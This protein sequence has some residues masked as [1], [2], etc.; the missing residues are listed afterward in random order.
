MRENNRKPIEKCRRKLPQ[1]TTMNV[2]DG[3]AGLVIY[4]SLIFYSLT[5]DNILNIIVLLILAG[6]TIA[7]LTGDNGILTNATKAKEENAKAEVIDQAR[8]DILAKQTEKQGESPTAEE[9]E[10][11]L[12]PKYGTLSNE[13]K[14][15]DRTL[16]T[17]EGYQIL[18]RDIWNGS[19]IEETK[20]PIS[21]TESYVGN[22]ADID[23][24][25]EI[26]GIIYADLAIGNTVEGGWLGKITYTITTED[27]ANLKD[28]YIKETDH[29][30][31]SGFGTGNVITPMDDSNGKDRFYVMALTDIGEGQYYSWYSNYENLGNLETESGFGTGKTNTE[32]MI[33]L[34]NNDSNRDEVNDL[35]GYIKEGWFVP[36]L[37][38]WIAFAGELKIDQNNYT[39]K[40]LSSDYWTS[41]HITYIPNFASCINF[42]YGATAGSIYNG[43]NFVRLSTTF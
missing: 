31:E 36:S 39:D 1:F 40:G 17:K 5:I 34:W 37:D 8:V 13:E 2:I 33:N 21:K 38:E 10:E 16:T 20:T 22:Y 7:T 27:S 3:Q 43:I 4:S 41:S 30:E 15:L 9:L 26:D 23:G 29:T 19:L 32:K 11:I 6:V 28:Y 25:G 18:V 24:D 35:W 14:I 12:T 42:G